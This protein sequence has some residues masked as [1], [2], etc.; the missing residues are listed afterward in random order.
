MTLRAS[1][2]DIV[3][4]F[5]F[6][7]DDTSQEAVTTWKNKTCPFTKGICTK[8]NHDKTLV[9]GTCSVSSGVKQAE[10][11]EIIV[12]PKR[13]YANQYNIFNHVL[14]SA[15]PNQS[16]E[17]LVGGTLQELKGK[18]IKTRNPVVAFGQKSGKEFQVNSNGSLS[19][20]WILQSYAHN[21]D[22]LVPQEFIGLEIQSIDITGNYRDNWEAYRKIK[23]G[24]LVNEVPR[25]GHGLNWANVHKRLIP[26]I[27]R[28]GNVY[29]KMDRCVG[30][31]FILPD[32]VYKKFEQVIG[33]IPTVGGP[34]RENLSVIT[35]KLDKNTAF[36][37]Q[38]K[39]EMVRQVH[40]SLA[41]IAAAFIGN[42]SVDAPGQLEKSLSSIFN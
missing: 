4:L 1:G 31:Y 36:G 3:E 21:A 19:M 16:K 25:S 37:E 42:T 33:D 40:Y 6:S 28:K 20:D 23:E 14:D 32:T 39:L 7:P 9:Y 11:S 34:S 17:L 10:G 15:W 18:A 38:R 2:P 8:T 24:T 22:R 27:I 5:G 30:F 35:F 26:Q 41:E 13:L 29:S 12:C